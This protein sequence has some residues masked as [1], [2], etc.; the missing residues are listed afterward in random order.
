MVNAL[1]DARQRKV[2]SAPDT[3]FCERASPFV[4]SRSRSIWLPV[5][6]S[7]N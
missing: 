7:Q 3:I 1:V 2:S 6:R 5:K 4:G